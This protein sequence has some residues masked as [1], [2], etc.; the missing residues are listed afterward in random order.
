VGVKIVNRSP[1]LV[2]LN[3]NEEKLTSSGGVDNSVT[4]PLQRI[5]KGPVKVEAWLEL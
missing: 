3:R 4:L 1:E 2:K 5:K